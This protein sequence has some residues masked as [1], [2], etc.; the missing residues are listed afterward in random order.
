[1]RPITHTLLLISA[2]VAP[3]TVVDAGERDDKRARYHKE[4]LDPS[5]YV[6]VGADT[7]NQP[8]HKADTYSAEGGV[9]TDFG[10]FVAG[11][12]KEN[13][14]HQK[15]PFPYLLPDPAVIDKYEEKNMPLHNYMF[16]WGFD[17]DLAGDDHFVSSLQDA[18]QIKGSIGWGRKE[19]QTDDFGDPGAREFDFREVPVNFM[20]RKKDGALEGARL[21]LDYHRYRYFVRGFSRD[22]QLGT[23]TILWEYRTDTRKYGKVFGGDLELPVNDSWDLL[24]SYHQDQ[25]DEFSRSFSSSNDAYN[26]NYS[27]LF[28]YPDWAQDATLHTYDLGARHFFEKWALTGGLTFHSGST[29]GSV[30][31]IDVES[32]SSP[33]L[34]VESRIFGETDRDDRLI[35]FRFAEIEGK[36]DGRTLPYAGSLRDTLGTAQDEGKRRNAELYYRTFAWELN[37]NYTH[38]N[39][40]STV[41]DDPYQIIPKETNSWKETVYGAEVVY[42][43]NDKWIFTLDGSIGTAKQVQHYYVSPAPNT[44]VDDREHSI[45]SFGGTITRRF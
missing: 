11:Y 36:N 45:H 9:K 41:T 27:L 31:S 14:R 30:D 29:W 16:G 17:T 38:R 18:Y 7:S 5:T 44:G 26:S 32:S 15:F 20:I 8:A 3:V 39:D 33:G 43:H 28:Y 13:A 42:R 19:G 22:Y 40:N 2:L 34:F 23:S 21:S 37:L 1:M 24:F 4:W 6:K 25:L 35:G 12:G 10:L